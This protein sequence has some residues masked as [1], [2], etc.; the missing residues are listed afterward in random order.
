MP[1]FDPN[2]LKLRQTLDRIGCHGDQDRIAVVRWATHDTIRTE[3]EAA[4][5]I[6]MFEQVLNE[7]AQE[8]RKDLAGILDGKDEDQ[9]KE[10]VRGE[11]LSKA[12]AFVHERSQ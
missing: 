9:R 12:R 8:C 7:K 1:P 10:I 4:G 2:R 5:E 11:M 6:E 3:T